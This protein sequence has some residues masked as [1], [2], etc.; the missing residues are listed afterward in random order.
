MEGNEAGPG[1]EPSKLLAEKLAKDPV[2]W[3]FDLAGSTDLDE[4]TTMCA[5]LEAAIP[6]L[7]AS[8]KLGVLWRIRSTLAVIVEE[9]P[10]THASR[11]SVAHRVLKV[12]QAP[13]TLA[14]AAQ[15]LLHGQPPSREASALLLTA[16]V[17]GA[18]VLYGAR[19]KSQATRDLR[20]RFTTM[21]RE[22]G[23]QAFPVLRAALEKLVGKEEVA[24]E[25]LVDVLEGIPQIRDDA[26][27]EVVA[28]FLES[29]SPEIRRIATSALVR[30]WGERSRALLVGLLKDEDENVRIA[31]IGEIRRMG[32]VEEHI[33][34]KLGA[35]LQPSHRMT[36]ALKTECAVAFRGASL[37]G[38]PTAVAILSRLVPSA[39]AND[40]KGEA[41][42]VEM[43]RSLVALA[44]K[45]GSVVV[46]ERASRQRE[47]LR[48]R[49]LALVSAE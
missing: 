4:F 39:P 2:R 49:L 6:S 3:L 23:T 26:T 43:A 1:V 46:A 31:A 40:L 19:T 29:K 15:D 34:R 17:G 38:R 9:G 35:L 41:V 24:S 18:Y 42:L 33:V 37:G 36:T 10:A 20:G 47:P 44:P 13:Q 5:E 30:C 16:G 11:P 14:P 28:R 25:L 32:A 21:M 45:E 27:G 22:I 12:L 7:A 8:G 48:A